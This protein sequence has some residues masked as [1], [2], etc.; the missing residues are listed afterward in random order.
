MGSTRPQTRCCF[1]GKAR[2]PRRFQHPRATGP[3]GMDEW[4]ARHFLR[5]L[6]SSTPSEHSLRALSPST[7][8]EHSLRALSPSTFSKHSLRALSP[9]ASA[10]SRA[11]TA[12]RHQVNAHLDHPHRPEPQNVSG[13]P[14]PLQ[15]PQLPPPASLAVSFEEAV[16]GPPSVNL[17]A[18]VTLQGSGRSPCA[19]GLGWRPTGPRAGARLAPLSSTRRGVTRL[20]GGR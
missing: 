15:L 3:G 4:P 12:P 6:P 9:P 13:T 19:K 5:A 18:G 7:L 11:S 10:S 16:V 20:V 8:S 14:G 17:S 1:C 2:S